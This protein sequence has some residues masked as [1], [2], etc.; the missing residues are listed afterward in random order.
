MNLVPC[1]LRNNAQCKSSVKNVYLLRAFFSQ[2]NYLAT[3]ESVGKGMQP[4]HQE[5]C[6]SIPIQEDHSQIKLARLNNII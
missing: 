5:G 4:E 6:F 3:I 1:L 2:N